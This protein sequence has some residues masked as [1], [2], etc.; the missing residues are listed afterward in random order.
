[1]NDLT[2]SSTQPKS[3]LPL[4]IARPNGWLHAVRLEASAKDFLTAFGREPESLDVL[5]L[6]PTSFEALSVGSVTITSIPWQGDLPFAPAPVLEAILEGLPSI[7][8]GERENDP[9]RVALREAAFAREATA[10]RRFVEARALT[11]HP[12]A[13]LCVYRV[14]AKVLAHSGAQAHALPFDKVLGALIDVFQIPKTPGAHVTGAALQSATSGKS[15]FEVDAAG[16]RADKAEAKRLAEVEAAQRAAERVVKEEEHAQTPQIVKAKTLGALVLTRATDVMVIHRAFFPWTLPAG[17][18]LELG[19]FEKGWRV[20]GPDDDITI[21]PKDRSPRPPTEPITR[22]LMAERR[23]LPLDASP[24]TRFVDGRDPLYRER[25]K[26][27]RAF[28]TSHASTPHNPMNAFVLGNV[29]VRALRIAPDI[30]AREIA[31]AIPSRNV[32]SILRELAPI[33][34]GTHDVLCGPD[35]AFASVIT[36][37]DVS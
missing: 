18:V 22:A 20:A 14:I 24:I 13:A 27:F 28:L 4:A 10:L 35:E 1:M 19:I 37:R 7:A 30:V 15:F 31:E 34:N 16:V 29:G 21:A 11:P 32:E 26:A 5:I 9:D 36:A 33:V 6:A 25:M 2:K 23:K 8:L 3:H 12:I 17:T